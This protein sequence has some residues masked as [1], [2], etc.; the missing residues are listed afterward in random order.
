MWYAQDWSMNKQDRHNLFSELVAQHHSQLYAY[1]LAMVRSHADADDV[2]QSVYL[3]LWRKFD[4]F[5]PGT[6]RFYPWACQTAKFVVFSFLRHK[7]KLPNCLGDD[8]VDVLAE[9][10]LE[11]P[12]DDAAGYLTALRRC[13][14]KL[15]AAD[16]ELLELRYAQG[17]GSREIADR[18]QRPQTSVCRSL[19]RIR[20]ALYDCIEMELERQNPSGEAM[21]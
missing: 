16:E 11:E 4:S 8:L 9:V 6:S 15:G 17:L 7:R 14:E 13:R 2:F 21:P 19:N 12:E 18:L 10:A 3:V 1:I 5:D 20:G